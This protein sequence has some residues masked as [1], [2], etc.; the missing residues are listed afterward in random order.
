MYNK[1]DS[2]KAL[3]KKATSNEQETISHLDFDSNEADLM[4]N[5]S[6]CYDLYSYYIILNG[7]ISLLVSL[8][9]L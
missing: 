4:G 5:P 9:R 3:L 7:E 6:Q 1:T 2:Y 8:N